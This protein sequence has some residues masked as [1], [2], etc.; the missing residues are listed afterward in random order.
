MKG[1]V[2]IETVNEIT[3]ERKRIAKQNLVTDALGIVTDALIG[4]GENAQNLMPI[5]QKVLGG[6][7]LFKDHL[8]SSS[9]NIVFPASN[10]L[11]AC[12]G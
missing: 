2:E 9:S 1:F 5:A 6:I 10:L 12:A 4:S 11:V 3:G 8:E 7:M